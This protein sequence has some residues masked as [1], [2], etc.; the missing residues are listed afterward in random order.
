VKHA[1]T[2][3]ARQS[4]KTDSIRD[5]LKK[6]FAGKTNK[7]DALYRPPDENYHYDRCCR[8]AHF[9]GAPSK[10]PLRKFDEKADGECRYVW[11][12]I[13]PRAWCKY[14][15]AAESYE[16]WLKEREEQSADD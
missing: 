7:A 2:T 16:P 4:G 8:C 15:Q 13:D 9:I 5:R 1:V 11:G 14:F 3:P 10:D 6:N 12:S